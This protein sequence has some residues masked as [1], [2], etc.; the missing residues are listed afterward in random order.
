MA[1]QA[2]RL[3]S[4]SEIALTKLDVLDKFDEIKVCVAYEHDGV[5][6][7]HMPF[8][9]SVLHEVT[10]IY[11][12]VPGWQRGPLVGDH[13]DEMPR[14]AL[15][16]VRFLERAHWRAHR[17]RGRRPRAR[18]V[19]AHG[20]TRCVVVGSGAR[21][22]ALAWALAQ[23]CRRRRHARATL[24]S[25]RTAISCVATPARASSTPTSL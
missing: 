21:E 3:N 23:E 15:D 25:R 11:E 14:A 18:A 2:V 4:L 19:R 20:V 7:D 8:H 22:H 6:Y 5:R 9:Q 12:T 1:R 10:P 13:V 24:A 17:G 16:Y